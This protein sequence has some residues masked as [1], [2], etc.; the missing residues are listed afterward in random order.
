MLIMSISEVSQ[1]DFWIFHEMIFKLEMLSNEILSLEIIG[2]FILTSMQSRFEI[3]N[4]Q[5]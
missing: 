4:E 3:F 2:R 1:A 5:P